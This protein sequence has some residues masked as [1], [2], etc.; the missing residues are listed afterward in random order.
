MIQDENYDSGAWTL[1]INIK[2][3][4]NIS[5]NIRCAST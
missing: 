2:V 3:G 4:T 5:T 1:H